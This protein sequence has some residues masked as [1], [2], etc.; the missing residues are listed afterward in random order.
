MMPFL[1]LS[2][3]TWV[4][5]GVVFFIVL[6]SLSS[7]KSQTICDQCILRGTQCIVGAKERDFQFQ[8]MNTQK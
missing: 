5:G 4:A 8:C 7:L 1:L 2:Y 3:L 6:V